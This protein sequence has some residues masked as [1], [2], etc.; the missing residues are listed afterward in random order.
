MAKYHV[1]SKTGKANICRATKKCPLGDDAVHFPTEQAAKDHIE[2]TLK[3]ASYGFS[4]VSKGSESSLDKLNNLEVSADIIGAAFALE[5]SLPEGFAVQDSIQNP[6]YRDSCLVTDDKGNHFVVGVS[7]NWGGGRAV[8]NVVRVRPEPVEQIQAVS[9]KVRSTE[10]YPE[11]NSLVAEVEALEAQDVLDGEDSYP[12]YPRFHDGEFLIEGNSDKTFYRD[13]GSKIHCFNVLPPG[14]RGFTGHPDLVDTG[15][16]F[17]E[18]GERQNMRMMDVGYVIYDTR[19]ETGV[20]FQYETGSEGGDESG[21][22]TTKNG[23]LEGANSEHYPTDGK[24]YV[25]KGNGTKEV[26]HY[27]AI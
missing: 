16:E 12:N 2:A 13:D 9:T 7:S 19:S 14:D 20:L 23:Y 15:V 4:T 6:D 22:F 3:K 18:N 17:E 11:V 5:K 25:L 24:L 26:D 8:T 10:D 1:N 21:C 27:K